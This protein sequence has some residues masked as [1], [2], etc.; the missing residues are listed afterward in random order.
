MEDM[1]YKRFSPVLKGNTAL[2]TDISWNCHP[3]RCPCMKESTGMR[4]QSHFR[5]KN[6]F[7]NGTCKCKMRINTEGE[8]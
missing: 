6:E 1:Q 5:T 7:G 3:D 4:A 8:Y 2:P